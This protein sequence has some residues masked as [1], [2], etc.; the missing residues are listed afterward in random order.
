MKHLFLSAFLVLSCYAL[1]AQN[2]KFG[3]VS[4]EEL[5]EKVHPLDSSANAAVLYKKETVRFD[6]IQ[7]DGFVQ[8]REVHERIKIYN[9]EGFD[10]ATRK[11][12]LYNRSNSNSEN[13]QSLKGYT[14]NLVD[15]K[16]EE[17]KLK[18]DGMFEEVANK[19]WKYESF[20]LPNIK[21]GCVV[22]FEYEIV[23]PY[24]SI[25]DIEFQYTIPI[26][27]FEV[28]VKTPEY[29]IYNKLLNPRSSYIP[30]L[31]ESTANRSINYSTN[32]RS[33]SNFSIENKSNIS[34]SKI[35]YKENI[36][37][38]QESNIPALKNEPLIDN[39][40]NY[41]AK[42]ILE[43]TATKYPNE[44]IKS[45]SSSWDEVTKSIYDS[46]DFGNQLDRSGYYDDDINALLA[47]E[48]NNLKKTFLIYEF[49]KSKVKW[50]NFVGFTSDIGV[51]TAYKEGAGNS[52]DINLMLVSML[53]YAGIKANPVLVSTKN[54]GIPLFPTRQGFNYV[55]CLVETPE[56]NAL[57]DATERYS[58]INTLP[59]RALNWQGRVIRENG[60]SDWINL[61]PTVNSSEMISLNVKINP[62]LT[63]EG[64]VRSQTTNYLA[65]RFRDRFVNL[66]PDE[67]IKYLEKDKGELVITDLEIENA[68]LAA[69][70]VKVNYKYTLGGGIEE[71]GD[72][73]YFSPL[74]FLTTKENPFKEDKRDFPIDLNHP[75]SDKYMI[76]IM[77]P[78]GYK[79]EYLPKNEKFQF[80][81]E[82]GEFS[83][84][85][86]ENG[87][88]L[89]LS[90][91]FAIN[92]SLVLSSDY[93]YFKNFYGMLVEKQSEKIIL[94]KI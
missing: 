28:S 25:D 74:L 22:E 68:Q 81:G 62:D 47:G 38:S 53:R 88:F 57:L 54:N 2:F 15:G 72:K 61:T 21:E 29:F 30:K 48:T 78:E 27:Q 52:A 73:L 19:Y 5:K 9:K 80:N 42:L 55:I 12:R 58:T 60:S 13:L 41:R 93:E 31:I 4:E 37:N 44:P 50:N 67:Y 59:L 83:Y 35:D 32:S 17:D 79:V 66:N 10:W 36:I 91:N 8:K 84:L 77:L 92:T 45:F 34:Q 65:M 56:F 26:N 3:K 90:V 7:G 87:K 39:L 24:L 75:I 71:I 51:R 86:I 16:I 85:A 89:Q 64:T 43:H 49:V 76:N 1:D 94:S 23:S 33:I 6:Y 18:R 20:T 63:I 69:E 40:D 70:P 11:I 46:P 14:Y 82:I